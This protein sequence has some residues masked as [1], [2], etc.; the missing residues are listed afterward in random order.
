M[1]LAAPILIGVGLIVAG[2][3]AIRHGAET[4][5]AVRRRRVLP[6]GSAPNGIVRLQGRVVPE[7]PLLTAPLSGTACVAFD[8]LVGDRAGDGGEPPTRVYRATSFTLDDGTGRA[9]V[10]LHL[11]GPHPELGLDDAGPP[12]LS[13]ALRRTDVTVYGPIQTDQPAIEAALRRLEFGWAGAAQR[14]RLCEGWLRPGDIVSVV[15]Y[16]RCEV[17]PTGQRQG[18]RDPG[19]RYLVTHGPKR[20][21]YLLKVG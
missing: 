18:Y 8:A 3:Y 19:R 16:G 1:D 7:G 21:L 2:S 14:V 4:H 9:L 20:P 15:G 11:A 12:E 10:R 6:V 5:W 13:C 17:D